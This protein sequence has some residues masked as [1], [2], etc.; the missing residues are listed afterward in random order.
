M[1][2]GLGTILSSYSID[3]ADLAPR[4]EEMGFDSIWTGEQP[5]LPVETEIDI[6][7]LWGDIPDP[8]IQLARASAVTKTLLLG[9]AVCVITERHPVTFAKEVASLDMY[10]GGRVLL[11]IG[12]GSV[13]EEAAIFGSDFSHRWTQAREAVGALKE[14]WTKE[15]SEWDGE[16][17]KFPPLYCFPK[18]VQKPHPPLLFGSHVPRVFKRI[19]EYGDGWIP[20]DRPPEEIAEAR[21]K[22]NSLAEV[23]GRDPAEITI[24]ATGVPADRAVIAAYEKAGADRVVL[25][26]D[27]ADKETSFKE[28]EKIAKEAGVGS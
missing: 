13:K 25:G 20:I 17:Y 24:T 7:R 8:L 14:L 12:T 5:V 4:A 15:V 19:V 16:Y 21:A 26:L 28:L 1:N 9:T 6:P 22:L 18:P 23:A 3:I 2:I 11:G 10:S 27:N